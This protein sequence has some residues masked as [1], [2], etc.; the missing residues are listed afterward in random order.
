MSRPPDE[1]SQQLELE[2]G[3]EHGSG[4]EDRA[5]LAEGVAGSQVLWHA[6]QGPEH[7]SSRIHD[8]SQVQDLTYQAPRTGKRRHAARAGRKHWQAHVIPPAIAV[9]G[10][11]MLMVFLRG[12][13][14]LSSSLY[15]PD[16]A[17]LLAWG[18]RAT[19][20]LVPYKTYTASDVLILWPILLGI[21]GDIGTHLSLLTAH[22]LSGLFYSY[23]VASGWYLFYRQHGWKWATAI[24]VPPAIYLFSGFP[25]IDFLSLGSELLPI[26][27]IVTATLIL[28]AHDRDVSTGRFL[29]AS[30]IAGASIWAKPQLGP[31]AAA[32]VLSAVLLRQLERGVRETDQPGTASSQDQS[33]LQDIIWGA[34]AFLAPTVVALVLIGFTGGY[35]AFLKDSLGFI[36]SETGGVSTSV[37]A[38]IGPRAESVG[39]FLAAFP[40]AVLWALGGL[41]GWDSEWNARRRFRRVV[42]ICAW[43]LPLAFAVLTLFVLNHIYAHY[44]NILYAGAMVSG[45]FGC[46][47]ARISGAAARTGTHR[48]SLFR[49]VVWLSCIVLG[50]M[51]VYPVWEDAKFAR[52]FASAVLI[53]QDVP[54]VNYYYYGPPELRDACPAGSY[55]QVWGWASELYAYYNWMPATRYVNTDYQ[56]ENS[57][58][59]S[60]YRKVFLAELERQR[61]KCIVEVIGPHF[62]DGFAPTATLP[63]IIPASRRFLNH[64]YIRRRFEVGSASGSPEY[65]QS[66]PVYVRQSSCEP[67][68]VGTSTS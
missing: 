23:L 65:F 15:N 4:A 64:C 8:R 22:V 68:R 51:V 47:V 17:T 9:G 39:G 29:V 38:V 34:L 3:V 57:K 63:N 6:D 35:T 66:V 36:T 1:E 14:L 31:L 50:L 20:D 60:Y 67:H 43:A 32:F 49:A 24:I 25:S 12:Q 45:I 10:S 21:L 56:I 55:V 40:F 54:S 30:A 41:L 16:E 33:A 48:A 28:F 18:R 58:D 61:P 2:Q 11:L 44:A 42:S 13:A 62:V 37:V 27:I 52:T 26:A 5:A 46:R 59:T 53:H 19:L 7:R